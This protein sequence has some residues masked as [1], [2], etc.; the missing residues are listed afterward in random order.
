MLF[1]IYKCY[2]T[3]TK[4]Q[5]NRNKYEHVA[6]HVCTYRCYINCNIV[7]EW[8]TNWKHT[9]TLIWDAIASSSTKESLCS[10]LD[11]FLEKLRKGGRTCHVS[12][13]TDG[14]PF[15][16]TRAASSFCGL[17]WLLPSVD[18]SNFLNICPGVSAI[19]IWWIYSA[20]QTQLLA[21][22]NFPFQPRCFIGTWNLDLLPTVAD[23]MH[24]VLHSVFFTSGTHWLRRT[25][26][27]LILNTSPGVLTSWFES[28]LPPCTR[29]ASS[30]CG[31]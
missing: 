1:Y 2:V 6:C 16:W 14:F 25:R 31:L 7:P 29:A 23:I 8:K 9:G 27:T 13:E 12:G 30:F 24:L 17:K 10:I 5:S 20:V 26:G 19:H 15:L 21:R 11:E 28:S 22:P 18:S 3:F 4:P